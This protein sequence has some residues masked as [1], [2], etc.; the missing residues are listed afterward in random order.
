MEKTIVVSAIEFGEDQFGDITA[1]VVVLN[2]DEYSQILRAQ[3]FLKLM[4]SYIQNMVVSARVYPLNYINDVELEDVVG[5]QQ[6]GRFYNSACNTL[7]I[8]GN[9]FNVS[10]MRFETGSL[11]VYRD[12]IVSRYEDTE[13]EDISKALRRAFPKPFIMTIGLPIITEETV[14]NIFGERP[15]PEP[16]E[17]FM[18]Y[19]SKHLGN[20]LLNHLEDEIHYLAHTFKH[21]EEV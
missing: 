20:A 13:S 3:R 9:P 8:D 17:E 12:G 19:L 10:E 6:A 14:K 1:H 5:K 15:L 4:P 16:W 21:P 7:V 18:N 11:F 2:D